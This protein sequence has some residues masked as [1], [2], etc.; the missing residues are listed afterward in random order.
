MF[1]SDR[2]SNRTRMSPLGAVVRGVTAS[3][4][5]TLA[6]LTMDTCPCT[7]QAP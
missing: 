1:T 6:R 5:G 4:L 7:R 3:A 2:R